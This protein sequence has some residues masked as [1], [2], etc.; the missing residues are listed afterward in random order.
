[1]GWFLIGLGLFLAFA[2]KE[3]GPD[4]GPLLP[5]GGG[6][7]GGGGGPAQDIVTASQLAMA[8][9]IDLRA[10]GE[11]Y[12]QEL[13]KAFQLAAGFTGRDVDGLYGPMTR[14]ALIDHGI[15]NPP[16]PLY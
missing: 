4:L 11:D 8:V 15:S 2:R 5:G 13:L 1:M 6:G 14:Q 16:P 10:Q 12:D 7:G 3:E 9:D